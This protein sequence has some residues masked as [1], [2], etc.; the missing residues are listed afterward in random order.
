MSVNAQLT[1]SLY[2]LMKLFS[3]LEIHLCQLPKKLN[4]D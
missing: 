2:T 3:E 1:V 4:K